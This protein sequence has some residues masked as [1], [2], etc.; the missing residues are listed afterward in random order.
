M[1]VQR[2]L[3]SILWT[4]MTII[5]AD[6]EE[7][8]WLINISDIIT[9][10][11]FIL[12]TKESIEDTILLKLLVRAINLSLSML[13]KSTKLLILTELKR[14]QSIKESFESLKL[15]QSNLASLMFQFKLHHSPL[16][17][18]TKTSIR[19]GVRTKLFMR[20]ALN[21]LT[22]L[23]PSEETPTTIQHLYLIQQ[24]S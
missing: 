15:S 4:T 22:I 20:K 2:K 6:L 19:T 7:E 21:S 16:K 18:L 13:R 1:Q 12:S 14:K 8:R 10:S 9:Q 3:L 23:C 5:W 11:V 17:Q 24:K